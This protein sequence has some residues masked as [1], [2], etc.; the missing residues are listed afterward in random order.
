MK[1]SAS[2][3]GGWLPL[4]KAAAALG[5]STTALHDATIRGDVPAWA[6]MT[7]A[8]QTRYS[9]LWCAGF[10]S[11]PQVVQVVVQGAA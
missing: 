8:T 1:P 11:P 10:K 7:V 5:W 4:A 2:I 9:A 6:M 3:P